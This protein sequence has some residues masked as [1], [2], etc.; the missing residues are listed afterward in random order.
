MRNKVIL[1]RPHSFIVNDMSKLMNDLDFVTQKLSTP[2]EFDS[3]NESEISGV[4]VSTAVSSD[5]KV[6]YE[7]IVRIAKNVFPK[8]PIMFATIIPI[9]QA[10][11]GATLR[12]KKAV[13][14][15]EIKSLDEALENKLNPSNE[16]LLI[17]KEDITDE[18]RYEL[19]KEIVGNYFKRI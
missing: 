3:L 14:D 10:K 7:E 16:I 9:A 13:I 4:V 18:K 11:S 19:T 5:V 17:G 2:M 1:A 8:V 6:D 15:L 12:F